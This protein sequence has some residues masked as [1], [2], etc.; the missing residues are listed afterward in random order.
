MTVTL[1]NRKVYVLGHPAYDERAYAS[2]LRIFHHYNSK[3]VMPGTIRSVKHVT[4]NK[5]V[6][7]RIYHDCS[8]LGGCSGG[9]VVDMETGKVIA[10]HWGGVHR[11]Q[12]YALPIWALA[13]DLDKKQKKEL[14]T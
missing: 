5:N 2:D 6:E 3:H 1:K 10:I 4:V 11:E 12:N 13:Q 8:T 7:P 14:Y 9:P